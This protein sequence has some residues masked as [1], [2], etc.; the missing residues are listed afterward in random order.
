MS[1]SNARVQSLA[2]DLAAEVLAYFV[3]RV[4]TREDAADMLSE[5]LTVLVRRA[6]HIPAD[7]G[8]ARLWTYGVARNVLSTHRRTIRRRSALLE[9]LREELHVT[10]ISAPPNGPADLINAALQD[11]DPIDQEIIRLVHWEGFSQAE[12][13]TVLA[14]PEG[15]VRS[16]YARSRVRL[17]TAITA[18][19][20]A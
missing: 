7:D 18:M 17:K 12:V 11:L 13:A 2:V 16:R 9:R 8:E 3:R 15:T 10:A 1:D 19:A 6:R 5:T 14:R 4:D 20:E